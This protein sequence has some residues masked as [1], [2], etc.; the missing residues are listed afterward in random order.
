MEIL[1]LRNVIT[2]LKK[3]TKKSPE[4]F[5]STHY[6]VKERISIFEDSHL[7]LSSQSSKKKKKITNKREQRGWTWMVLC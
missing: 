7:K 5:Y 4:K 6:Q 2:E 3:Q 1:E